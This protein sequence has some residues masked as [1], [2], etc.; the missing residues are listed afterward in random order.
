MVT[1]MVVMVTRETGM[2]RGKTG[3]V[4]GVEVGIGGRCMYRMTGVANR[5]ALEVR[6]TSYLPS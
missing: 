2:K 6:R 5:C 4:T 1:Y 3:M